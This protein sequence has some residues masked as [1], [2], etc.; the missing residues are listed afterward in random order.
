VASGARYDGKPLGAGIG[1]A[2]AIAIEET[3]RPEGIR[4]S[5]ALGIGLDP[6]TDTGG[7]AELPRAGLA[8]AHT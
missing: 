1:I 6:E 7:G 3:W 8:V 5:K 4:N 2:I